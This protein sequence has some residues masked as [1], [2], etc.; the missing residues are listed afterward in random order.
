MAPAGIAARIADLDAELVAR[1]RDGHDAALRDLL[2]RYKALVRARVHRFFLPGAEKDDLLQE[3]MIGLYQAIMAFEPCGASFRTFAVLCIDRRLFNAV[4][5]ANRRKFQMLN[6][7]L[8]IED[9]ALD[10]WWTAS[11]E[12]DPAEV[13]VGSDERA[14]IEDAF[15]CLTGYEAR[16]LSLFLEGRTYREIGAELGRPAKSV[17]NALW[18]VRG[19]LRRHLAHR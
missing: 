5:H 16:V 15:A 17:D 3:G 1:V 9:Q 8:S 13:V 11:E 7:A 4:T 6:G 12:W 14:R 19:K 10:A 18:R 2:D